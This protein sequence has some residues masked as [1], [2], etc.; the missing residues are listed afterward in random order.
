VLVENRLDFVQIQQEVEDGK[1]KVVGR[2]L[3][4]P[5]PHDAFVNVAAHAIDWLQLWRHVSR[6]QMV[7]RRFEVDRL[8][9]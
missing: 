8:W 1:I 7:I 2:V 6:S 4:S 5:M 3:M 9:R